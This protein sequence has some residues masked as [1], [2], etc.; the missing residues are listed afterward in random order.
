[1]IASFHNHKVDPLTVEWQKKVFDHFDIPLTQVRY[2]DMNGATGHGTAIDD[3]LKE[4]SNWTDYRMTI[5]DVDAI[6]VYKDFFWDNFH[7]MDGEKLLYGAAQK[8][9]H[10]E[11]SIIYVAPSFISFNRETYEALGKPSF[12]PTDRADCGG[13]LTW[14]AMERGIDI[15]MLFP[16]H[17]NETRW[18]L[19]PGIMFGLGTT[20]GGK[21]YH[22]FQGQWNTPMFVAK[23]KEVIGESL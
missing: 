6:P 23:A 3:F 16:T 7:Q 10:I 13:E 21:V 2:G 17:V 14:A 22:A 9:S 11:N 20:Y 12:V 4:E 5:F 18:E 8:S 1:M 15:R 19:A